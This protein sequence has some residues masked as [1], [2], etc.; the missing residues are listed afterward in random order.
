MNHSP[1]MPRSSSIWLAPT[2]APRGI[3]VCIKF[4]FIGLYI[5]MLNSW[6]LCY[7]QINTR[8][9]STLWLSR[10]TLIQSPTWS[11]HFGDNG[12]ISSLNEFSSLHNYHPN[13]LL[14]VL[15][16][17]YTVFLPYNTRLRAVVCTTQLN[18]SVC[19]LSVNLCFCEHLWRLMMVQTM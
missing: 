12:F 18:D 9:S 15:C 11:L 2:H 10:L 4:T 16:K 1:Q 13:P 14:L 3:P 6:L 17:A 7:F 5:F 19:K 8:L